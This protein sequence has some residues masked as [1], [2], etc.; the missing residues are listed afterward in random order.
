MLEPNT[1]EEEQTLLQH[2][3]IANGLVEPL[4]QA[5]HAMGE[6][7]VAARLGAGKFLAHRIDNDARGRAALRIGKPIDLGA[8]LSWQLDACGQ[9]RHGAQIPVP[10]GALLGAGASNAAGGLA[11]ARLGAAR[12]GASGRT[13]SQ[14][15]PVESTA[16]VKAAGCRRD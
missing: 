2:R 5:R 1:D 4:L 6:R 16:D 14:S 15:W 11:G 12:F 10:D 3:P 13:P 7:H 8:K 9:T